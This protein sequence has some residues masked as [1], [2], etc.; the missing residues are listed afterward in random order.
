NMTATR[1]TTTTD[2]VPHRASGYA[3]NKDKLENAEDWVAVR[4][5]GAFLTTVLDMAKWDAALYSEAIL[6]SNSR[7]QMWTPTELNDGTTHP[8]GLGWSLD[9]WQGHKRVHHQGGL[10]GFLS[11][12]ERFVDDKLTVIVMINST[13]GDPTK[14]ALNVAGFYVPA[15]T[16][17]V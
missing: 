9:P 5:S 16:P 8:Y 4:P 13:S 1:T 12:F 15:L 3:W 2:I 14:I 7:D 6:S 11:D 17:I 10:P